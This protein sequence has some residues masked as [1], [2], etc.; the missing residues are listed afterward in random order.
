ML[1][2]LND[3]VILIKE[4]VENTTLSGIILSTKESVNDEIAK[5]IAVG[6]KC[7]NIEVND[8]VIY[9]KYAATEVKYKDET[10]YVVALKDILAIVEDK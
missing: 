9:S 1:K 5:V 7:S 10:Y 3:N 6:E 4:K 2:P 8:R